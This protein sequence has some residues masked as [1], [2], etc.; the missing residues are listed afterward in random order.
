[1][2]LIT[3]IIL[4]VVVFIAAIFNK[5]Y[6]PLIILAWLLYNFGSD[7]TGIIYFD[8]AKM[9]QQLANIALIFILLLEDLVQKKQSKPCYKPTLLLAT[10]GVLLTANIAAI[11]F[12]F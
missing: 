9:A 4:L 2:L 6:I 10:A 5:Q 12:L 11:F 8:D 7:V 3:S 1:M